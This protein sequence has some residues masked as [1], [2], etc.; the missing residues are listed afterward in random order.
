MPF[1]RM[2]LPSLEKIKPSI[3]FG[4]AAS[5]LLL[6]PSQL[7]AQAC[8]PNDPLGKNPGT[9]CFTFVHSFA[10]PSAYQTGYA[11]QGYY[12]RAIDPLEPGVK[13]ITEPLNGEFFT[14][15]QAQSGV[16]VTVKTSSERSWT[17]KEVSE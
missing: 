14:G 6:L 4:A 3:I 15:V 1:K 17:I 10:P 12:G 9:L 7:R 11:K 8:L 2:I 5:I 13:L 16:G